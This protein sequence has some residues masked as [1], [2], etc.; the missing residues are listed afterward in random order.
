MLLHYISAFSFL[1]L[2]TFQ[3]RALAYMIDCARA[4]FLRKNLSVSLLRISRLK[5]YNVYI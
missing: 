2:Q 1:F 3:P 5:H 4:H